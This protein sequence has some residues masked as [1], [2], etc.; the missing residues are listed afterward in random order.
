[1]RI[2]TLLSA[3]VLSTAVVMPSMAA[4]T[5]LNVSYDVARELFK[6]INPAFVKHYQQQDKKAPRINQSHGGSSKQVLAVANG[7]AGDVVTMNQASDIEML[8]QRGLVDANWRAQFPHNATPY[9]STSVFL[10]RKG[11]PKNIQ[12][13]DDL[14]RAGVAVI[15]PNPKVSGNGRYAYLAAWGFAL[16]KTGNDEGARQFITE[17]FKN[18]PVLDGGGRGATTTFTQ[19]GIGDVLVTFENETLLIANE[20]GNSDFEIIYPSIS[21]DAAAPVAVV[22]RVTQK[23]GTE[24]IAKDYLNFLYST[25]GQTIIAQHNFRPRDP[26][27]YAANAHKFPELKLFTVEEKLGGWQDVLR[28]HFADGAILDQ[29]MVNR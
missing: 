15:I 19:R 28:K 10:V 18:V 12:D 21:I 11:N 23:R 22:Q 26:E 2:K 9:T 3:L 1:M 4:S 5:F 29:I 20:L 8:E 14:T 27:V 13:W 6:D 7:L 24:Q 17:L 25:E 16:D